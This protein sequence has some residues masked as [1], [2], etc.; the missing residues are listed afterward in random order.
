MKVDLSIAIPFYNEEKNIK[1]V[2]ESTNHELQELKINYEIIA[3]NNGS[4]D[5]T[6]KIIKELGKKNKNIKYVEVKINQGYGYGIRKGLEIAKGEIIGFM[7]GD[8]QVK[9]DSLVKIWKGLIKEKADLSKAKR[10]TKG[11]SGLRKIQ[12][13]GYNIITKFLFDINS[14]DINGCP[15][16]FKK[17]YYG[18]MKIVSNDWFI[19]TEIMYKFSNRKLKIVETPVSFS[20]RQGGKS[21]IKFSAVIE[22]LKNLLKLK[23]GK[24]Y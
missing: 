3:I 24:F 7:W 6:P 12:S 10:K 14:K 1:E 18:D 15:K 22:F 9:A 20:K 13:L 23:L 2:L 16:L 5:N 19:D 21:K 17:R 11:E 8:N 4:R